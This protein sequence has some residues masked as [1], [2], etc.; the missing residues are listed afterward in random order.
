[1]NY[2]IKN[3][4]KIGANHMTMVRSFLHRVMFISL[5]GKYLKILVT[6]AYILDIL[7]QIYVFSV[8][9]C[10]G[11]LS[12][13]DPTMQCRPQSNMGRCVRQS[14]YHAQPRR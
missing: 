14:C 12:S 7:L 8:D 13:G 9:V 5:S 1:M 2:K 4:K 3:Y 6:L 11:L 10:G